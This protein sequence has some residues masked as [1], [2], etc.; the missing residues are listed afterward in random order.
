MTDI[1][2]IND[3]LSHQPHQF[4]CPLLS[5]YTDRNLITLRAKLSGAVY[6][7]LVLSARVC[8]ERAG[9]VFVCVLWVCYHDNSKLHASILTKLGL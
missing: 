2:T 4:I 9:G 8:N 3:T 6:M 7:F 1:R 5:T